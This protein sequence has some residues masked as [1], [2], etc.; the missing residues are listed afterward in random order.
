MVH[1]LLKV[2]WCLCQ[3]YSVLRSPVAALSNL[4]ERV[5]SQHLKLYGTLTIFFHTHMW[6]FGSSDHSVMLLEVQTKRSPVLTLHYHSGYHFYIFLFLTVAVH[7]H[8]EV[9]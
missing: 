6:V 3:S 8:G 9:V 1:S 4:G 7:N 5:G 2:G